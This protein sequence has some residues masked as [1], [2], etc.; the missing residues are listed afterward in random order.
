[1]IR[2]AS[3]PALRAA[4]IMCSTDVLVYFTGVCLC[5]CLQFCQ[6]FEKR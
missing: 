2:R 3:C 1:M 5:V 6:L 4:A